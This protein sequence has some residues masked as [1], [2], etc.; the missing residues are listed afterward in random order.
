MA[1]PITTVPSSRPDDLLV[2]EP[3]PCRSPGPQTPRDRSA[4][5]AALHLAANVPASLFSALHGCTG[6]KGIF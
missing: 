3:T 1:Y 5:D 6:F 2:T 4:K